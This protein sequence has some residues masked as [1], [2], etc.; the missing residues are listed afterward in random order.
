MR[1]VFLDTSGLVAAT[2]HPQTGHGGA[3]RELARLKTEGVP[4]VLHQGIV[5]ELFDTLSTLALREEAL[6]LAARIEIEARAERVQIFDLSADLLEA[7]KAL[8]AKRADKEW[9]LTD[10]ISFVLMRE[11][12]I[13]EA[14]SL[15]HH[16]E[17]AGF[18][19]LIRSD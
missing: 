9:G 8:F 16:F 13:H 12:G 18:V 17:Q 15:D 2:F 11:L 7:G 6:R 10:C 19:L 5:I 4:L 3:D 1:R 14:F